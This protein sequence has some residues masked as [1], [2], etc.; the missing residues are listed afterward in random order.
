M[1]TTEPRLAW[2]PEQRRKVRAQPQEP[3]S[4]SVNTTAIQSRSGSVTSPQA[5]TPSRPKTDQPMN[6]ARPA[7]PR[8]RAFVVIS[9]TLAAHSSIPRPHEMKRA[10]LRA[11]P[12]SN[13]RCAAFPPNPHQYE[14]QRRRDAMHVRNALQCNRTCRYPTAQSLPM[15]IRT[16]DGP[17]LPAELAEQAVRAIALTEVLFDSASDGSADGSGVRCRDMATAQAFSPYGSGPHAQAHCHDQ[18]Q[19]V[20]RE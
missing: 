2:I 1:T 14:I 8:E 3:R 7:P 18:A 11:T 13:L 12:E 17:P 10:T 9:H 16:I 19:T 4:S 6:P 20:Q 15:R 5:K